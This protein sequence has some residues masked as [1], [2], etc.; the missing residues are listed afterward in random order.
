[1]DYRHW[2]NCGIDGLG[3]CMGE[4]GEPECLK[5][6]EWYDDSLDPCIQHRKCIEWEEGFRPFSTESILGPGGTEQMPTDTLTLLPQ[7]NSIIR[8]FFIGGILGLVWIAYG[9]R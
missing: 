6:G 9:N 3:D 1:M 7:A 4:N 2:S 5:W 8:G